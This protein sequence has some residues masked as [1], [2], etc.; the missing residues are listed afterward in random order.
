MLTKDFQESVLRGE[1]HLASSVHILPFLAQQQFCRADS[2]AS[3]WEH[4]VPI[5]L[6]WNCRI[7]RA[8]CA[9][10]VVPSPALRLCNSRHTA[11]FST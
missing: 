4:A 8:V 7:D 5:S 10:L 1:T 11:P 3:I 6:L 9:T 2:L